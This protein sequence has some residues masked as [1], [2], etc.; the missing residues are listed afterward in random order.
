MSEKE[1]GTWK[2]RN[3]IGNKEI[4]NVL[5]GSGCWI[6]SSQ[7]KKKKGLNQSKYGSTEKYW[8]HYGQSMWQMKFHGE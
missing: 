8:K 2:M 5:C 6:I 4:S 7:V 3:N 1:Q